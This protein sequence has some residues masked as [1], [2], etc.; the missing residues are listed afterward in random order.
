MF[1]YLS[2]KKTRAKFKHVV[3]EECFSQFAPN[4]RIFSQN[5]LN[6]S[7]TEVH[8]TGNILKLTYF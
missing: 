2:V 7:H 6:F 3:H 5:F 8:K 1:I 4:F